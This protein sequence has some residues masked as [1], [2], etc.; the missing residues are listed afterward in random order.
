MELGPRL[1]RLRLARGLTQQAL[2]APRYTH[3]YVSTIEAGRRVP[4]RTA[5]EHFA[6]ALNVSIEELE[7]GRP[8][9]L[10]PKLEMALQDARSKAAQGSLDEAE[11]AYA[12]V[13]RDAKRFSLPRIRARAVVGR[14][15]CAE[16]RGSYEEA[17]ATYEEA[18]SLLDGEPSFLNADAVAGQARCHQALGDNHFA[19]HVL[20]RLLR[21]MREEKAEH[22]DALV[23]VY[24][25]L[26][27]PYFEAGMHRQA[28]DAATSARR[29]GK[30]IADPSLLATMHVNVARVLHHQ[31]KL[32]DAVDSLQ[33]A[34]QL[35]SLA[36]RDID[37]AIAH[38]ALGYIL[39]RESRPS[40]AR[41]EFEQA[42]ELIDGKAAPTQLAIVLHE[43]GRIERLS[44]NLDE[45]SSLLSRS[46]KVARS[47]D[48]AETMAAVHR[49]LGICHLAT[50][51]K[52]AD[53][54]LKE[55]ISLYERMPNPVELAITYRWLGD[56]A[57]AQ[58]H[59]EHCKLYRDALIG[60]EAHI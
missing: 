50:D 60:L 31:G 14:G 44:G 49:E 13:E 29:Y 2:A 7:T 43:L 42:Q 8:S 6:R 52:T 41:R 19:I 35:F 45:A 9:D 39:A 34:Q 59:D 24:A 46:L 23:R 28:A 48:D 1:R 22:P 15:N 51:P 55:A 4:S 54:H 56:L 40:E 58:G 16:R 17:I 38:L 53:K 37:R 5:L 47:I 57:D 33:E 18:E 32:D 30:D 3:A 21:A 20:E 11:A 12:K 26:V 27:Q 36:E 10:L 25:G